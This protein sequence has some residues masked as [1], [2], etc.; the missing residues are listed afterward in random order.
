M[1]LMMAVCEEFTKAGY[2]RWW[3]SQHTSSERGGFWSVHLYSSW[4]SCWSTA[5]HRHPHRRRLVYVPSVFIS[6]TVTWYR[7]CRCWL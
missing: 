1:E 4:R 3:S 5:C 2:R 7:N 6:L